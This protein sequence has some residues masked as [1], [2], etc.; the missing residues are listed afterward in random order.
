ME[1]T[2][3]EKAKDFAMEVKHNRQATDEEV[4]L[5]IAWAKG[6]VTLTQVAIAVENRV[7]GNFNR[8]YLILARGLARYLKE[9]SL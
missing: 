7:T 6:D 3:L 5:A 4:E 9:H 1:K 2:L 8:A